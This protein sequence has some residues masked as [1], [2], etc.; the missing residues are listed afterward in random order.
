MK[1][2]LENTIHIHKPYDVKCREKAITVPYVSMKT[3]M[4][5]IKSDT[6]TAD[7]RLPAKSEYTPQYVE[8]S[9][10]MRLFIVTTK[11]AEFTV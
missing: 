11:S 5:K 6:Q 8:D 9:Y 3:N 2:I 4:R 7:T 1:Y 10:C